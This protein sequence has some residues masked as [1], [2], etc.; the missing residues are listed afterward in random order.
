[1]VLGGGWWW[2]WWWEE[3]EAGAVTKVKPGPFQSSAYLR[4]SSPSLLFSALPRQPPASPVLLPEHQCPP[5]PSREYD[6][7]YTR[8]LLFLVPAAA[9]HRVVC[10]RGL[11]RSMYH[12]SCPPR[13]APPHSGYAF[14]L[15]FACTISSQQQRHPS[16]CPPSRRRHP[17]PAARA[18]HTIA[19]NTYRSTWDRHSAL[20]TLP[21][22][23]S[24]LPF[25]SQMISSP[26]LIT[27]RLK[28]HR[29]VR[30]HCCCASHL[31]SANPISNKHYASYEN[32]P[33]A[34]TIT[35]R[36]K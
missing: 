22:S 27:A 25:R 2:W 15:Q 14:I 1:M 8:A 17:M 26:P 35:R 5:E 9:A 23:H 3:E 28:Q 12:T 13:P 21:Q 33:R 10:A 29:D 7:S 36:Q 20:R 24:P 30:S 32:G 4:H 11:D 16:I 19:I 6:P 18:P 31:L 34:P